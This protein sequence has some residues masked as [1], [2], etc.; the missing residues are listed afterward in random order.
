MV[1]KMYKVWVILH[2]K[3]KEKDED[4][5]HE[6]TKDGPPLKVVCYLPIIP[7]I[8]HLFANSND[9]KNLK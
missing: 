6:R 5:S 8:K 7:R 1:E 2:Y 4:S 9:A 3:L